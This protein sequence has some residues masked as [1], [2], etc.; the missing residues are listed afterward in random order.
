MMKAGGS[1]GATLSGAGKCYP[2]FIG[3]SDLPDG[4]T[5]NSFSPKCCCMLRCS[6]CDKR[7][8]RFADDVKWKANVDYIFVRNYNTFVEKLREGVESAPGFS[9]YACQCQW[10]SVNETKRVDD[11]AHLRWH[12]RGH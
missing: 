11:F 7:V 2:L 1:S 8:V 4:H 12:C 9:C 5:P 6:Q 3:G 10:V